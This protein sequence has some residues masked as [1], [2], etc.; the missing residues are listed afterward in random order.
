[1]TR[2]LFFAILLTAG[3]ASAQIVVVRS[4]GERIEPIGLVPVN[5]RDA[6]RTLTSL[7]AIQVGYV[8]DFTALYT[9]DVWTSNGRYCLFMDRQYWVITEQEAALF[10]GVPKVGPPLAYR[11]PVGLGALIA[12]GALAG[13]LA[14]RGK[15]IADA[16]EKKFP[17]GE[18]PD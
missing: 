2:A 5:Q 17:R 6:V 7:G 13:V 1:M 16:L 12:L 14:T 3:G 4:A 15:H 18:P 8:F 11:L 10:L 9:L